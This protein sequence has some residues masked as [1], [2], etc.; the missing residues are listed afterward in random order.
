MVSFTASSYQDLT[1]VAAASADGL[2]S[3]LSG[4]TTEVSAGKVV[5]FGALVVASDEGT[6][7]EVSA[8]R[9][10]LFGA[11]VVVVSGVDMAEFSGSE[12]QESAVRVDTV[13]LSLGEKSVKPSNL[14][15]TEKSK[16]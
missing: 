8:G 7:P 11:A 1:V 4:T 10:V 6:T 5:S 14:I 3:E 12:L 16:L 9:A 15:R 2:V 13:N